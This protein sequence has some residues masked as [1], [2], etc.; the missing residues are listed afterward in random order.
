MKYSKNTVKWMTVV[1]FVGVAFSAQATLIGSETFGGYVDG[2]LNGANEFVATDNVGFGAYGWK[3]ATGFVG[4]ETAVGLTHN[5][6]SDAKSGSMLVKTYAG[7]TRSSN[8]GMTAAIPDTG[9]YYMSGL[10]ELVYDARMA[11]GQNIEIGFTSAN[12]Q[13]VYDISQGMHL[14]MRKDGTV[15]RLIASA[16]NQT[17]DI[18][19]ASAGTTYQIVLQLDVNAAGNDTLTAWYAADGDTSLTQG[20]AATSVETW[21][22]AGD[23]GRLLAQASPNGVALTGLQLD[24]VRLGTEL[25]DVTAIPEPATLGLIG[26]AAGALYMSRRFRA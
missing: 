12:P 23:L 9:T 20:L 6:I 24:E 21:D 8:R 13:Y 25:A 2:A 18:G 5:G 3:N 7:G 10:V 17:W 22:A 11:D 26:L 1:A 15:N 4:V 14:G 19:I 16:G